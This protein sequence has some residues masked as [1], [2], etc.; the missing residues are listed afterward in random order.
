MK[1]TGPKTGGLMPEIFFLSLSLY[2]IVGFYLENRFIS[3]PI[4]AAFLLLILLLLIRKRLL[5][6]MMAIVL[7]VGSALMFF[8]AL[9]VRDEIME[10]PA[11]LSIFWIAGAFLCVAGLFMAGLMFAQYLRRTG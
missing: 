4:L 9:D 1:I 11:H 6:L 3:Y 8:V 10:A 2:W 5:G 7:G